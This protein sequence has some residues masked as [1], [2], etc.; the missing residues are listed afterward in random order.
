MDYIIYSIFDFEICPTC[1][2]NID[3]KILIYGYASKYAPNITAMI[4]FVILGHAMKALVEASSTISDSLFGVYVASEP[5]KQY[6]QSLMGIVG[7]DEG[8][9]YRRQAGGGSASQP[10]SQRPQIP[11]RAQGPQGPITRGGTP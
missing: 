4:A 3:L 11:Q 7:L 5:G 2:L 9:T 10:S 8:S 1:I 6:Q